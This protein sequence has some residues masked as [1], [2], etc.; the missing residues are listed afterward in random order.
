MTVRE[1]WEAMTGRRSQSLTDMREHRF[2]NDYVCWLEMLV[3][4]RRVQDHD[5]REL[6]RRA[7]KRKAPSR[8]SRG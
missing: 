4:M 8:M 1:R 6:K 7:A 5:A 2:E 3:D